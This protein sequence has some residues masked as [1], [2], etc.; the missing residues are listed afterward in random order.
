MAGYTMLMTSPLVLA[1]LLLWAGGP[2]ATMASAPSSQGSFRES[3]A[4][5][6]VEPPPVVSITIEPPVLTPYAEAEPPVVLP[7]YLL[8]DDGCEEPVHAGS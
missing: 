6:A 3:A 2:T 5:S 7:G 4:P 8:P 1:S